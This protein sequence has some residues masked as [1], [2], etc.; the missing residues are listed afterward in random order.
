METTD[1]SQHGQLCVDST[2]LA[3]MLPMYSGFQHKDLSHLTLNKQNVC[4]ATE[5]WPHPGDKN[6]IISHNQHLNQ[7]MNL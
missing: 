1:L 5:P 3:E 6:I 7:E 4:S 2:T